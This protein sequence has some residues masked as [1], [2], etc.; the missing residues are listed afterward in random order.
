MDLQDLRIG[1]ANLRC[2]SCAARVERL[3][4]EQPGVESW[5]VDLAQGLLRVRLAPGAL[6]R[7]AERLAEAGYPAYAESLRLQI[8]GLRCAGCAAGLESR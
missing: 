3:V 1:L 4:A 8:Q 2:A 7:L 5:A 6:G